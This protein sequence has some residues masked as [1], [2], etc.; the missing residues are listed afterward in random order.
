MKQFLKLGLLVLTLSVTALA[1]EQVVSIKASDFKNKIL[2][3]KNGLQLS[4]TRENVHQILRQRKPWQQHVELT[5]QGEFKT[6]DSQCDFKTVKQV[7]LTEALDMVNL[8]DFFNQK[9]TINISP[10]NE[11]TIYKTQSRP[12]RRYFPEVRIS[13]TQSEINSPPPS[14]AFGYVDTTFIELSSPDEKYISVSCISISRESTNHLI[15]TL[16]HNNFAIH[17]I[18]IKTTTGED[19]KSFMKVQP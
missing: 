15:A 9:K 5:Y 17:G 16:I 11:W 4:I 12:S 3:F 7:P 18:D 6:N 2:I 1:E 19:F 13:K 14:R 10:E 8:P